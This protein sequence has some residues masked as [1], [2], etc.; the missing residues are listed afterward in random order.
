MSCFCISF[1]FKYAWSG[2][3]SLGQFGAWTPF[4]LRTHQSE[5]TT[6]LFERW[7]PHYWKPCSVGD[8][9]IPK[10]CSL[11]DFRCNRSSLKGQGTRRDAAIIYS[12]TST[13][14]F[15]FFC[16]PAYPELSVLTDPSSC[17]W[18]G[19][20]L[21]PPSCGLQGSSGTLLRFQC[22]APRPCAESY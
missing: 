16:P 15:P 12:S 10:L 7:P 20:V 18:E 13:S 1:E 6:K 14:G 22:S 5:A 19:R 2:A 21:C 4:E 17:L 9:Q 3:L 8:A 11:L